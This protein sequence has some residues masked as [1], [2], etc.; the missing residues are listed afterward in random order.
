MVKP[1]LKLLILH[2]K[3]T[4]Q[5]NHRFDKP[6]LDVNRLTE[7]KLNNNQVVNFVVNTHSL[8]ESEVKIIKSVL[9]SAGVKQENVNSF[10]M[11]ADQLEK[12][13]SPILSAV[14]EVG[15]HQIAE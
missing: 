12:S 1:T 15:V 3:S 6:V 4:L 14:K 2:H 10:I 11:K 8:D 13:I 5:I 9:K 7:H